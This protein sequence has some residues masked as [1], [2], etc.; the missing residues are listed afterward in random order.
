[1]KEIKLPINQTYSMRL[2]F[3]PAKAVDLGNGVV[4]HTLGTFS[5]ED[6][7]PSLEMARKNGGNILYAT[8]SVEQQ[9]ENI[10]MLYFMGPFIK[11]EERRILFERE[12]LQSSAL[13]YNA[14]K[15]LVS[16]ILAHNEVVDNKV[17]NKLQQKL[18]RIMEWRNA[19][20]HGKLIYDADAGCSLQYYSGSAKTL[21]L[22]DDLWSEVEECFLECTELLKAVQ[23]S[24]E[25]H[26]SESRGLPGFD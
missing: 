19:F 6:A 25:K 7:A 12:I 14:K 5:T 16:K 2:K 9:L 22:T 11:H 8:T 3:D 20:A 23:L 17:L 18:K 15:E 21:S 4:R 24:V 13:S 10:L 1:M 26:V